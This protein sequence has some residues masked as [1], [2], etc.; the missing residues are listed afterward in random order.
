M[1]VYRPIKELKGSRERAGKVFR[2]D[3]ECSADTVFLEML[4]NLCQFGRTPIPSLEGLLECR[5]D[6]GHSDCH[7]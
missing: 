7:P 5:R 6:A 1:E 4:V 3:L 2:P